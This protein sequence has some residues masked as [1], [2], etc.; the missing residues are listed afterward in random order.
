LKILI[1]S[2]NFAPEPTGIGASPTGIKRVLHLLSFAITSI[3]LVELDL[4]FNMR[5]LSN[6]FVR[7]VVLR[8][9]RF[10]LVVSA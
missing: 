1:Y 5:L 8:L 6:E 2:A 10:A 4:A 9:E 7:G 3:P